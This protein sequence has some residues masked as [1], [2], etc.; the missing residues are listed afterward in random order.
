[1]R[2]WQALDHEGDDFPTAFA[3]RGLA[4]ILTL[5]LRGPATAGQRPSRRVSPLSPAR[6]RKARGLMI[7]HAGAAGIETLAQAVDLSPGHFSRSFRAATGETP[8]RMASALRIEEAKRLL[9]ET[10]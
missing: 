5:L 3:E 2:M 6:L 10:D 1:M 9:T 8:H 4:T 7:D